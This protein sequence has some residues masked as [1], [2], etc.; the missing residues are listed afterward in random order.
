MDLTESDLL[1]CER[2]AVVVTEVKENAQTTLGSESRSALKR[3]EAS[4]IVRDI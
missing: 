1:D 3:I 2:A 4:D